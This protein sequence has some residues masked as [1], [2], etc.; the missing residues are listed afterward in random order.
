M[1]KFRITA[2]LEYAVPLQYD[3]NFPVMPNLEIPNNVELIKHE[4][5]EAAFIVNAPTQHEACLSVENIEKMNP[6]IFQVI[7]MSYTEI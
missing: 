7:I 5:G 4:M 1:K 2:T 3:K 6:C